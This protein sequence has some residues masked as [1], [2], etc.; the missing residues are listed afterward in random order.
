MTQIQ[1]LETIASSG[2][3]IWLTLNG[4]DYKFNVSS[5]GVPRHGELIFTGALT[6]ATASS[7]YNVQT[8]QYDPHG[9]FDSNSV[10]GLFVRNNHFSRIRVQF[11]SHRDGVSVEPRNMAIVVNSEYI[12]EMSFLRPDCFD[13]VFDGRFTWQSMP[14]SISSGDQVGILNRYAL[15]ATEFNVFER[16]F[17]LVSA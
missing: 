7:T 13:Q 10:H 16:K 14:F 5:L 4:L 15:S 17:S 6:S 3:A 9:M 12:P 11:S 2:S 1:S 8:A